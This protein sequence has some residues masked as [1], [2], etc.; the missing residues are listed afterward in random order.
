M[1]RR[2]RAVDDDALDDNEQY[3]DPATAEDGEG[4][5][6]EPTASE[7]AEAAPAAPAAA[8]PAAP[9]ARPEG[10]W[11]AE[12]APEDELLDLGGLRVPIIEGFDVSIT[13]EG[14]VP[15]MVSYGAPDGVMQIHAF[16]AP[17]TSGIWAEIRDELT[18]SLE[19]SGG[20]AREGDGPFGVEVV[21]SIPVQTPE[22]QT[23]LQPARFLGIDGPRWFLRALL[24]GPIL[25]DRARVQA[26][27]DVLRRTVVVRGTDAMAP[28]DVIPLRL[29]RE[30]VQA[31]EDAE[32]GD[33]A[34]D[35]EVSEQSEPAERPRLTMPERGPEIT[36]VR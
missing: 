13:A 21:A 34:A 29:P 35:G 23:V 28:R 18:E 12:D 16:A 19:Q 17:K 15:V 2:R 1:F 11:D 9:P 33:E 5:G 36:E 27:E 25:E 6:A 3:D 4:D 14:D 26:L 8:A 31:M 7:P 20:D 10:P 32:A 22:G 30:V 24:T